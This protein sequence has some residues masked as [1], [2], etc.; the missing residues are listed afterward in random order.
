MRYVCTINSDIEI[1]INN[2]ESVREYVRNDYLIFGDA[3]HLYVFF[4]PETKIAHRD[5]QF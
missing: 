5:I 3:G 4:D 2:Y 1:K